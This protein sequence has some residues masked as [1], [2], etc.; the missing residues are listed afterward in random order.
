M[1]DAKEQ[2]QV[3][4]TELE[5]CQNSYNDS[6]EGFDDGLKEAAQKGAAGKELNCQRKNYKL[7]AEKCKTLLRDLAKEQAKKASEMVR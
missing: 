7:T 1:W 4:R 2:L 6:S 3:V 5:S